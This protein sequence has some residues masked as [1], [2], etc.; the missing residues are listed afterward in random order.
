MVLYL[1]NEIGVA[2]TAGGLN[3]QRGV[4]LLATI[5]SGNVASLVFAAD[6]GAHVSTLP[7]GFVPPGSSNV[8]FE[9]AMDFAFARNVTIVCSAS[10]G[11]LFHSEETRRENAEIHSVS[12]GRTLS[13][14]FFDLFGCL[15]ICWRRGTG[16]PNVP[17]DL[18]Q[19]HFR[20]R[21]QQ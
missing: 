3:G 1:Q 11:T 10:N 5:P 4:S 17:V 19:G 20:V 18:W 7:W 15:M 6:M 9:R 13:Q 2:G 21:H 14:R 12:L 8:F 16:H